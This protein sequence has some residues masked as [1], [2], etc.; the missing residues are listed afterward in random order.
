[1]HLYK[2][3]TRIVHAGCNNGRLQSTTFKLTCCFSTYSFHIQL[4]HIHVCMLHDHAAH[5][6]P[7]CSTSS[8]RPSEHCLHWDP[9]LHA[10][11]SYSVWILLS[12]GE[13]PQCKGSFPVILTQM[14][15]AH[16]K[17]ASVRAGRRR[18]CE[19]MGRRTVALSASEPS[20]LW[21]IIVC[22][23]IQYI[24]TMIH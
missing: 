4:M 6:R 15:S 22:T 8:P 16:M 5:A 10:Y 3:Y 2:R 21:H 23:V 20:L 1:M 12:R 9:A 24:H 17:H 18:T 14:I 7:R 13:I 11:G 19:W